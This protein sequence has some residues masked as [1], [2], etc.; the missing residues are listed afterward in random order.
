LYILFAGVF[1]ARQ[2]G[3]V[4]L[5]LYLLGIVLAVLVA[6]L[7]KWLF[8]K[9]ESAPLIMEMPP[10]HVPTLR[11][12]L[13]HMWERAWLFVRKAGTIIALASVVIWLLASLPWGVKYASEASIIGRL[14][15]LLAPLL[16]PAGFGYWWAAVSLAAGVVAKEIVVSTMGA[17]HGAGPDGLSEVL[18]RSFT[19]L[20]AYAFMVMSLVYVPCIATIAAIKRETNWKWMLLSVGYTLALGWLLAVLINQVGRLLA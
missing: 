15:S 11:S 2:R 18:R 3:L 6:R 16:K 20:S 7:F 12:M 8:F 14:G 1:F 17:I 13:V 10:Y 9:S 4:V 5:S 19:P